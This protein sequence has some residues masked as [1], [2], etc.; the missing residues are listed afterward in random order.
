MK[1]ENLAEI[2]VIGSIFLDRSVVPLVLAKLTEDDFSS[3]VGLA[4][5]RT[6]S[7]MYAEGRA[8]DPLTVKREAEQAGVMIPNRFFLDAMDVT[9]TAANVEAYCDLLAEDGLR[10]RLLEALYQSRSNLMER[11]S[12]SVVC[13]ALQGELERMSQRENASAL[14][15]STEAMVDFIGYRNK[16]DQGETAFVSSGYKQLD[17]LLGGGFVKEGLYILAARP[18]VGKT[19]VALQIAERVA[20]RGIP[21]LFVSLEMSLEQ[22]SAK[23]IA[24]ECGVYSNQVLL[25]D[26]ESNG[27]YEQVAEASVKLSKRPMVFNRKAGATVADVGLMARQVKDCGLVVIDYMGLLRHRTGESLYE[28]VTMTSNE[29]KRMARSLGIPILCLAQ[30]SRAPEQRVDKR[31]H[32]SD[33]RDSGAIEQDADGV[34]LLYRYD[35]GEDAKPWEPANLDCVVEKNRHGAVGKVEF[36]LYLNIGRVRQTR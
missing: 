29:L 8:I 30:L 22:L 16:V 35:R 32:L 9:T 27:K 15:S 6:V 14:V 1:H 25:G 24:A 7:A 12:P 18:G 5:Y 26:L 11:E 28:R 21:T 20:S 23:R 10:R 13:T 34:L 36:N 31:P 3:E 19:T 4:V 33:L 17:S 2:N